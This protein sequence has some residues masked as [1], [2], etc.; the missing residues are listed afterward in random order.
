MKIRMVKKG[1]TRFCQ[2]TELEQF[3]AT[4]WQEQQL[5]L[6]EQQAEKIKA[7]DEVIRLRPP[8]KNKA[9][10]TALKEANINKGDE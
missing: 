1:M 3:R 2:P 4:G 10:V 6:F 8:V 7:T 5:T 9:T